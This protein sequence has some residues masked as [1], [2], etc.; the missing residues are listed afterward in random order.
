MNRIDIKPLSVNAAWCGKK[1]KTPEY[2]IYENAMSFLLPKLNIEKGI[3]LELKIN[4]G[5]SSKGSD[6]DNICKPFQ[7]ILTKK[8][9]FNDNQIYRLIMKKT[10]VPKNKEFI[11]FEITKI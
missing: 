4:V 8:Y 11:E 1:F 5:F 7:D 3:K 10:I 2:K 9:G 6:L